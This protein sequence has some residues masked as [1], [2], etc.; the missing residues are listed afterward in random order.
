MAQI[1]ATEAPNM[2]QIDL[3]SLSIQQLQTLKSQ[4]DAEINFFTESVGQLKTT[5][6]KFHTSK[7][8]LDTINPNMNDRNVLVPLTSSLYVPGKL[9]NCDEVM[10]DIGTRYYVKMASGQATDYF[11]R[12]IDFVTKQNGKIQQLSKEKQAIRQAILEVIEIK[13]QQAQRQS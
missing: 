7:E 6:N 5:L 10:I 4:L 11:V 8:C 12:K 13:L 9:V 1:S 3:M 2:Q